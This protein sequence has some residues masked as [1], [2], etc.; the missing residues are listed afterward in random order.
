M[1]QS[2]VPDN[3]EHWLKLRSTNINS[4]ESSALFG[5]NKYL[6]EFELWHRHANPEIEGSF[7]ETE[8]TVWGNRLEAAIAEGIR[9]ENTLECFRKKD[10]YI[11][12]DELKLGSSFDYEFLFDKESH[13]LEIKNVDGMIFKNEWLEDEDGNLEAP[14]HIELQVQQQMML[15]G[16][17]KAWI[18][19]LVGGNKAVILKREADPEMFEMIK[20]K[21]KKFW[22]S[23]KAGVPPE[24][25]FARD[26][27]FISQLY[28][29]VHVGK[30]LTTE[31]EELYNLALEYK[32]EADSAKAAEERKKAVKAK[33]LMLIG[34][35]EKVKHSEFSI[36]AGLIGESDISY[37]RK[38]FRDFRINWPRTKK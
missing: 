7:E 27:E 16:Y 13:I 11:W 19:A 24:P 25:D 22:D 14:L 5:I 12:D 6:T 34:D 31:S 26:A 33:M 10:E 23:I 38:G 32:Q 21:V 37:T 15:S 35:I 17:N 18:C 28:Q 3:K 1:I 20:L 29:S 30:T 2:V 4:T 8:R 9:E 36:S